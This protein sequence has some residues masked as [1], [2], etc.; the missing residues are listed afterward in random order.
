MFKSEA[1]FARRRGILSHQVR[2]V[3]PVYVTSTNLLDVD[4]KIDKLIIVDNFFLPFHS[5]RLNHL[6]QKQ[7]DSKIFHSMLA[8]TLVMG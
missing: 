7:H 1:F 3:E 5:V 4:S 6:P 8:E 2:R